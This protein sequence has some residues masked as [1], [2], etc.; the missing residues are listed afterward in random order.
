MG[1]HC[2]TAGSSIASATA[3]VP[4]T[5]LFSERSSPFPLNIHPPLPPE[6]SHPLPPEQSPPPLPPK[7]SPPLPPEQQ[8]RDRNCSGFC[9]R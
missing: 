8:L 7:C 9:V 2:M 1:M 3:T 5:P 6:Q 4:V